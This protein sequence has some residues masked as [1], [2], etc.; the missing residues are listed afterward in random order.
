MVQTSECEPVS[1]GKWLSPAP[2]CAEQG[3]GAELSV[4]AA[5]ATTAVATTGTATVAA[6]VAGQQAATAATRTDLVA[7][8][9]RYR[10]TSGVF[11]L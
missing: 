11:C 3:R 9:V 10:R 6:R 1:T 7:G 4:A 8:A 5:V 2:L